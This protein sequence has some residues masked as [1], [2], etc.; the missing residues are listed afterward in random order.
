MELRIL[1]KKKFGEYMGA[2]SV[3]PKSSQNSIDQKK[4]SLLP[5]FS[6]TMLDCSENSIS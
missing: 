1:F 5:W 2:P 3:A 6:L 4:Y